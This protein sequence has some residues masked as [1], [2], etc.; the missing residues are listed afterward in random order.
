MHTTIT[1]VAREETN[2][3]VQSASITVD[4]NGDQEHHIVD[5]LAALDK[6]YAETK[7]ILRRYGR[8]GLQ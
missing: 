7:S 2:G 8:K 5:A 3:W 4:V 1:H 6:A